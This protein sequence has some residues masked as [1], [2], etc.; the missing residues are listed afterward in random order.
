[1]WAWGAVVW[2][3]LLCLPLRDQLQGPQSTTW[4]WAA[5]V[6][7]PGRDGRCWPQH[8]CEVRGWVQGRSGNGKKEAQGR[9]QQGPGFEPSLKGTGGLDGKSRETVS[10]GHCGQSPGG[11]KVWTAWAGEASGSQGG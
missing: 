6:G 11:R 4:M 1:M 7:W 2:P 3:F 10:R 9:P 8:Q 5:L